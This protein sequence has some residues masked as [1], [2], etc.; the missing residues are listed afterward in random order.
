MLTTQNSVSVN[1]LWKL[2]VNWVG[3]KHKKTT[4][5]KTCRKKVNDLQHPPYS[6]STDEERQTPAWTS[7]SSWQWQQLPTQTAKR[8][9]EN[10][11]VQK[12]EHIVCFRVSFL[13]I[14]YIKIVHYEPD[15]PLVWISTVPHGAATPVYTSWAYG[16]NG[17][18]VRVLDRRSIIP[19]VRALAVSPEPQWQ[20]VQSLLRLC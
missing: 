10:W 16:L 15:S 14:K 6:A 3:L 7:L 13:V 8:D 1:K 11:V 19:S 2:W 12:R 9:C 17:A 5:P 4:R 20:S 18:V